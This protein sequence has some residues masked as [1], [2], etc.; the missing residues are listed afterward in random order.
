MT[1][2]AEIRSKETQVEIT[3]NESKHRA[4]WDKLK[5]KKNCHN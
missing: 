2:F 1:C 4:Y 3:I 5:K